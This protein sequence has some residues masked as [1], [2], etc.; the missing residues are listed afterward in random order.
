MGQ[1][2]GRGRKEGLWD[3]RH[4]SSQAHDGA[5]AARLLG[6]GTM[7]SA[8]SPPQGRLRWI[9]TWNLGPYSVVTHCFD[10]VV[11]RRCF[12]QGWTTLAWLSEGTA[13]TDWTQVHE[14]CTCLS[15]GKPDS[16]QAPEV[17]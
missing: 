12:P 3:R 8:E 4:Q 11:A 10:V 1:D 7:V 16:P 2:R 6:I 13:Q 9:N 5:L 14:V 17:D 15:I